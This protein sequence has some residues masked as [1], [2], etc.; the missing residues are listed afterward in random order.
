MKKIIRLTESDLKRI[1]ERVQSESEIEEG[2]IGDFVS[3]L[4]RLRFGNI[5]QGFKGLWK[6]EG[7]N[8]YRQLNILKRAVSKSKRYEMAYA[9]VMKDLKYAQVDISES[10]IPDDKKNEL[11]GHLG[12]AISSYDSYKSSIASL[13]SIVDQKFK[14]PEPEQKKKS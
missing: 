6:G 14:E 8:Y 13:G 5:R 12:R 7:Y 1:V 10:D 11:L 2:A 9:D 3:D 4:G